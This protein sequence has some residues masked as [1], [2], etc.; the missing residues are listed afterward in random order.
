MSAISSYDP[1]VTLD[2]E[3]DA[4]VARLAAGRRGLVVDPRLDDEALTG[5]AAQL[6]RH[7]LD[8]DRAVAVGGREYL[9]GT[10]LYGPTTLIRAAGRPLVTGGGLTTFVDLPLMPVTDPDVRG[11]FIADLPE[12]IAQLAAQLGLHRSLHTEADQVHRL[13]GTPGDGRSPLDARAGRIL[14]SDQWS[15]DETFEGLSIL[16]ASDRHGRAAFGR[17]CVQLADR[18]ASGARSNRSVRVGGQSY[19]VVVEKGPSPDLVEDHE[20]PVLT[21]RSWLRR[22][23]AVSGNVTEG[24]GDVVAMRRFVGDAPQL[25]Q[26]LGVHLGPELA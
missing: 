14:E 13:T 11:S 20:Q 17:A 19:R 7:L 25:A 15:L 3:L 18:I 10:D 9:G 26:A 4:I 22:V 21:R 12:I 16:A 24:T 5:V 2:E 6:G 8:L 23:P 1:S